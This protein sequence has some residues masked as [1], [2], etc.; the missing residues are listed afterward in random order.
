MRGKGRRQ[1]PRFELRIPL[2]IRP[3]DAAEAPA[4]IV[5]TSNIS[6]TGLY[7]ISN[8]PLEVGTPVEMFL[9]VPEEVLGT[10]PRNW[11]CKG[12]VVWI[13]GSDRSHAT[14]GVGV[15]FQYYEVL[16]DEESI[17]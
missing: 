3:L 10:S 1:T 16:E 8:L 4:R 17:T 9:Q 11:C 15:E 6:A 14:Q 12:R 7:F 5:R 13:D 2:S